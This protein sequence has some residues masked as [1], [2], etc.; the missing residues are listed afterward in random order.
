VIEPLAP[1][2]PALPGRTLVLGAGGFLG[3]QAARWLARSGAR[4]RLLDLSVESIPEEVRK[5][6]GV[7][8]VHGNV[9]DEVSLRRAVEGVDQVLHFISA[10]VPA[11][12]VDEVDLELRANVQPTL[13]LLEAMRAAGTPLLVFPSSGGT[14]YGDEAPET[15]FPET[16]PPRPYGS[17]GLGKLLTEEIL[18]F[19]ARCGGP[20]CLIL[21]VA[22]AYGPSV[23]GHHRQG[24]IN[25]FLARVRAGEPVRIWGDGSAVRDYVHVEDI[26]SAIS[27]LVLSG[28]RDEVYNVG[29]GRGH[30][31]RELLDV[32]ER[33][34]GRPVA[35][36][37]A[38]GEYSGVR[39][40]L[41]DISR[42]RAATGWSPRIA[43]TDGIA[44]LWS[45][46]GGR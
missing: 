6:A 42:L 1:L 31:V 11:T 3:S 7:E 18:R 29:C 37:H 15:G 25:A 46:I 14:I 16:T 12:S 21:R 9:L 20:R 34:T 19:R 35:L 26:L 40:N 17:Y 23:H 5:T 41:L 30:S 28:G 32:I 38:P 22:N 4:L 10:T 44:H 13:R 33:V 39:R 43:L 45:W 24:V 27:A 2:P 36:E 8:V